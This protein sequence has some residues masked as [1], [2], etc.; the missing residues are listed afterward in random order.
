V[1]LIVSISSLETRL[2]W[3]R[4]VTGTWLHDAATIAMAAAWHKGRNARQNTDI[5][6]FLFIM[7]SFPFSQQRI[8]DA[9]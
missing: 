4:P 6:F 3:L 2:S 8:D 9:E 7:P 5:E 1:V